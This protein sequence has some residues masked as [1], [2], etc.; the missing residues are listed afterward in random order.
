VVSAGGAPAI[1]DAAAALS[2]LIA[3]LAEEL[4]D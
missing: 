1:R 2:V 4:R 3:L